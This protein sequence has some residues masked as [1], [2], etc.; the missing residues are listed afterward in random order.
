MS[1]LTNGFRPPEDVRKKVEDA[2]RFKNALH[3][4]KVIMGAMEKGTLS[5][6]P[7]ADGIADTEPAFNISTGR[8]YEGDTLLYVKAHQKEH[9]FPIGEYITEHQ[10]KEIGKNVPG[11]SVKQGEW[12]K[13][14]YLNFNVP[15]KETGN[16]EQ[17]K[18]TIFN[19]AQT[20]KPE[21]LK[22]YVEQHKQAEHEKWIAQKKIEYGQDWE[23]Q[24]KKQETPKDN[25]VCTSTEPEK[26][27][28]QY[29]AA[30]SMGV[31][32]A[33]TMEQAKEFSEKLKETV[34][35]RIVPSKE[36]AE[37][38][39]KQYDRNDPEQAEILDKKLQGYPYAFKLSQIGN[40]AVKEGKAIEKYAE[41]QAYKMKQP[42]QNL[43]QTQA[44][45]R[46]M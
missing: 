14:A 6:L 12:G 18:A 26:Y 34:D 9:G 42:E 22:N 1:D 43:E 38:L 46:S 35:E 4:K 10:I 45:R 44:H 30:V 13:G 36:R 5:C 39:K 24:A 29:L 3:Q 32:F 37:A 20:T 23:P 17:V 25:I 33:A 15:N 16:W 21:E 40:E 31:K 11:L 41:M 7:N 8:Y 19:V 28:G 2:E 27:L